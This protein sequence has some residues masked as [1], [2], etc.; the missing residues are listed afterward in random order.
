MQIILKVK[1]LINLNINL[2]EWNVVCWYHRNGCVYGRHC[3]D[4]TR[5]AEW[6]IFTKNK[7]IIRT[8]VINQYIIS[9]TLVVYLL[10]VAHRL[11][12]INCS[13]QSYNSPRMEIVRIHR[14]EFSTKKKK[15][16]TTKSCILHILVQFR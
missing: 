7:H 10:C 13:I 5:F 11:S 2:D 4:E 9:N 1:R 12:R 3:A 15:I 8:S 14:I 6:L 16:M